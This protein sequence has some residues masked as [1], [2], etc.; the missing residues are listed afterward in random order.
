MWNQDCE[1]GSTKTQTETAL[2]LVGRGRVRDGG[3]LLPTFPVAVG[4]PPWII[5]PGMIR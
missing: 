1:G 4:S 3:F 5:K 2:E